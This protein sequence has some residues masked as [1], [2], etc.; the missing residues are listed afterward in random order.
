MQKMLLKCIGSCKSDFHLP[1]VNG[2]IW[3]VRIW[4]L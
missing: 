1:E 2:G 3:W 4:P